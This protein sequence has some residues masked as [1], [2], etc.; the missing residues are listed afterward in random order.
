MHN[1]SEGDHHHRSAKTFAI[2]R[3]FSKERECI[4]RM[5]EVFDE[6]VRK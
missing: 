2:K 3:W 1:G 5:E 4:I 6:E